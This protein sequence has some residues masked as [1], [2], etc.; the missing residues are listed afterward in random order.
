M[1]VVSG[2]AIFTMALMTGVLSG[3]Q[4]VVH[5]S[6]EYQLSS[7]VESVG[8]L[9]VESIWSAY[10]TDQGGFA[11]TIGS[12]RAFLD[13]L[14]IENDDVGVG[15]PN[16][17]DGF[18]WMNNTMLAGDGTE[19]QGIGVDS[20]QIVRRDV[21]ADASQLFVTVS[22]HTD[23]GGD[24]VNP[25]LNRAI[26]MVYTIEPADFEGFEYAML[27][28]NVNCIFCH[29]QIDSAERY[30]DIG[31]FDLDGDGTPD[32]VDMDGDGVYDYERVRVG[33][34]ESLMIR[35]DMDGLSAVNDADT[36]SLVAGTVYTRGEVLLHDGSP[37]HLL[38]LGRP[39]VQGLPG[40]E[41]R[42]AGLHPR[43]L[44]RRPH[45]RGLLPGHA[46]HPVRQLLRGLPHDLG[47]HD[48]HGRE[49]APP[50]IRDRAVQPRSGS[51]AVPVHDLRLP[52]DRR[53]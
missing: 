10:L 38:R 32:G 43:R 16:A 6:D 9:A 5:Q 30:F 22:A 21:L 44:V 31:Q 18:D 29:T 7:S 3:N 13:T 23:R 17:Q 53:R 28:N 39:D 26:Q 34:L 4:T 36:N 50:P 40:Q 41:R 24:N 8:T 19:F 35:H 52:A 11:G 49:L 12:F 51:V 14:G 46:R 47:G 42:N 20:V 25:Q 2:L 1:L 48:E 15:P 37:R 27:A 33:T 45:G